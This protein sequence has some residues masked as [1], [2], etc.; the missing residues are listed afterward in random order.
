MK[1]VVVAPEFNFI[2]DY[3]EDIP[4]KFHS[5]STVLH[6]KRNVIKEDS[7]KGI[8][9][10]IKS[11]SGIYLANRIRYT[12][13]YSSKAQRAFENAQILLKNG[14]N[15]PRPIAYIEITRNGLIDQMYFI[16]EFSDFEPLNVIN[17]TSAEK[18]LPL[19]L[20]IAQHT[21]R[22]HQNNIYHIDYSSGNILFRKNNNKYE[23]ALIDNNRMSFGDVTFEKGIQNFAR[24]E[25]PVE[26]LTRI[27]KDYSRLWRVNELVGIQH[28]FQYKENYLKK[29]L[30][31]KSLKN[32]LSGFKS[33]S[34]MWA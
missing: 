17:G 25:L 26:H 2:R 6:A 34:G 15:T 23:L 12:Y 9:L 16:C 3:I 22:L 31:K 33:I 13:F 27:A 20:E 21:F 32:L 28:L 18:S 14:F 30:R 10:V 11:Y 19:L 29:R 8:R 7:V 4:E 1:K 5:I 24:L